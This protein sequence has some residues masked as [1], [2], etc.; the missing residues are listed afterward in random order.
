MTQITDPVAVQKLRPEFS[1]NARLTTAPAHEPP[2]ATPSI[3]PEPPTVDDPAI[4]HTVEVVEPEPVDDFDIEDVE[5]ED[6][7]EDEDDAEEEDGEDEDED[8]PDATAATVPS[9]EEYAAY[10]W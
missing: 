10:G 7:N 4:L 1:D 9:E 2:P 5:D 8:E 6:L 3:D